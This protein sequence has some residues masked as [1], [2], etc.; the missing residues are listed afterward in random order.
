MTRVDVDVR[1]AEP[2]DVPDVVAFWH[3]QFGPGSVQAVPGRAEWLFAG[4]PGGPHIAM[5]ATADGAVVAAC[6]HVVQRVEVPEL[7]QREAVFG[8]DF[9]V[10][11]SFRRQGLGARMLDLRLA[12]FPLS[13]STGQSTEMAALYR[14][15]GALD[16]GG[17]W[18]ARHRRALDLTEGPR[19]AVR[20][21]VAMMHGRRGPRV[22]GQRDRPAT[23]LPP[24]A[25]DRAWLI[26]RFDGPVYRDYRIERLVG[27]H[28]TSVLV[29]RRQERREMLVHWEG[30]VDRTAALAL[31]A[32]TGTTGRMDA[33]FCGR[34]LAA[35]F[36]AAGYLVRPHEARLIG[37]TTDPELQ[38]V[39]ANGSIDL[40][41]GSADADLLR[42]PSS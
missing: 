9:M 8:L 31:A 36:A 12:R 20:G 21:L 13:L 7:G 16:L 2:D 37:F 40:F 22:D 41:A 10:D 17:F 30:P 14:S 32:R 11:P 18:L 4:Q 25:S 23:E 35:E 39:L 24:D 5:A 19:G 42:K 3:R 29:T 1:W 27:N 6:G 15:R 34:Q 28:G 38:A 26:W 33:L